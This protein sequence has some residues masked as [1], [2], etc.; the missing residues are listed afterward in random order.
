MVVTTDSTHWHRL[1]LIFETAVFQ[2]FFT[3][4]PDPDNLAGKDAVFLRPLLARS[5]AEPSEEEE[6]G[7]GGWVSLS[8]W[9]LWRPD[10][11]ADCRKTRSYYL[12]NSTKH[13]HWA[14]NYSYSRFDYSVYIQEHS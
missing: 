12:P 6:E 8:E 4:F 10:S 9:D 7:G 13:S 11:M 2:N 3:W 5:G 14:L 1:T